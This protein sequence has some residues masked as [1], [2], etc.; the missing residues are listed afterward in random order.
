MKKSFQ[1][2]GLLKS[3]KFSKEIEILNSTCLDLAVAKI[4]ITR[5]SGPDGPLILAVDLRN[6]PKGCPMGPLF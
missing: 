4:Y 2:Y 3:S 5:I 1:V 6:T